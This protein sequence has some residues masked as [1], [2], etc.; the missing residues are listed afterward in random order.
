MYCTIKH[1]FISKH[2][3]KYS[4]K[5]ITDLM[6]IQAMVVTSSEQLIW[7]TGMLC[8]AVIVMRLGLAIADSC[9][10]CLGPSTVTFSLCLWIEEST[11]RLP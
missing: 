10:K 2:L 7:M 3:I 11:K 9:F 1:F 8:C 5:K 6:A 4:S